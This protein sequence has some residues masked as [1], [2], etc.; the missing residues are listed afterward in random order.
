MSD[1][2]YPLIYQAMCNV[3]K[4]VDAIG[5][6]KRN[7]QQG[8]QYRGIDDVYNALNQVMAKHGVFTTSELLNERREDRVTKS[9]TAMVYTILNIRYRFWGVDGSSVPTEVVG[10]GSDAGDKSSNKSMA[11]AHKYALLQAFCIPTQDL[12]LDD[13]DRESHEFQAKTPAKKIDIGDNQPNTKEAA[14]YVAKQKLAAIEAE[15]LAYQLEKQSIRRE[16][17]DESEQPKDERELSDWSMIW[18]V[19]TKGDRDHKVAQLQHLAD[20][21][22]KLL[23]NEEAARIFEAARTKVNVASIHDLKTIGQGRRLAEELYQAIQHARK[24]KVTA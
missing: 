24:Q 23:P 10:E 8:F 7:S 15:K 19:M 9:G 16:P 20:E 3:M 21:L 14:A 4:D 12:Q 5:K 18:E 11:I 2:T 17:G 22:V 6:D 13:P 1:Q